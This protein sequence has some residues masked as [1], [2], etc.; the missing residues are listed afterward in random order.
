MASD[1]SQIANPESQI[2]LFFYTRADCPLCDRLEELLQPHLRWLRERTEV[3]F[4]PRDI[5]DNPAWREAYQYRI[6]VLTRGDDV[7]L[8]GRPE[9]DEVARAMG[10]LLREAS[11]PS[12]PAVYLPETGKPC[13][14]FRRLDRDLL[15][16]TSAL[17]AGTYAAIV[18]PR[19]EGGPLTATR[20]IDVIRQ[21]QIRRRSGDAEPLADILA[22]MRAAQPGALIVRPAGG[23]GGGVIAAALFERDPH[24]VI[25]GAVVA[26][27]AAG[28]PRIDLVVP[29]RFVRARARLGNAIAEVHLHQAE[30]LGDS[31]GL[32]T[33]PFRLVDDEAPD[34]NPGALDP[35]SL[36]NLAWI[37]ARSGAAF[38]KYGH[39][40]SRGTKVVC[41]EGDVALPGLFEVEFGVTLRDLVMKIAGGPT[42]GDS[43]IGVPVDN[44][45][46]PTDPSLIINGCPYRSSL[47]APLTLE[48]PVDE[49]PTASPALVYVRFHRRNTGS[50]DVDGL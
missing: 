21:S 26:A 10:P 3:L 16:L 25:E 49:G 8:E 43:E 30:L 37:V 2:R 20:A 36:C 22:R 27:L 31:T 41:V 44:V 32:A 24:A 12:G 40:D 45:H 1:Q 38:A 48:M 18:R 50:S 13:I 17:G 46:R 4:E 34:G 19:R 28:A 33:R 11:R 29:T 39:D 35:E 6:P 5:F 23:S 47:D 15:S 14:V 9:A 7:L 42:T